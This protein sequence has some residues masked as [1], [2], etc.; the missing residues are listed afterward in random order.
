MKKADMKG[1]FCS[2]NRKSNLDLIESIP[3]LIEEDGEV[4]L[5]FSIP[6]ILLSISIHQTFLA[7]W[8]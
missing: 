6:N 3:P 1:A 2:F 7:C 5:S 8:N 4:L